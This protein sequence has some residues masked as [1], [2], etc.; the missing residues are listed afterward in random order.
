[1]AGAPPPLLRASIKL[2]I[3]AHSIPDEQH[4][5][6]AGSELVPAERDEVGATRN[7]DPT[8]A[9]TR[10]DVYERSQFMRAGDHI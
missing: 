8:W 2:W 6:S 9:G 4:A 1:M 10:V 7:R 3:Q 5:A